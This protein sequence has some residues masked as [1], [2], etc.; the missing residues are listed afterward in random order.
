L[1]RFGKN[2]NLAS[3]KTSL[4]DMIITYDDV[5]AK[6]RHKPNFVQPLHF[7]CKLSQSYA[8]LETRNIIF[9]VRGRP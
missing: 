7:P 1:I 2:Q 8:T 9:S 6:Y 4:T 5:W 3:P